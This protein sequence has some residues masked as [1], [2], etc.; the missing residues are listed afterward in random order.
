KGGPT[1]TG[2]SPS[3]L[4]PAVPKW[5][6]QRGRGRGPTHSSARTPGQKGI[7]SR[8]HNSRRI[9][10][11]YEIISRKQPVCKDRVQRKSSLPDYDPERASNGRVFDH[12][13][14]PKRTYGP[15][16]L[17]AGFTVI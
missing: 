7:A 14:R 15:P 13:R 9:G 6:R 11:F 2:S 8:F 5:R 12:D 17:Q 16:R 3:V 1:L 10:R 4:E